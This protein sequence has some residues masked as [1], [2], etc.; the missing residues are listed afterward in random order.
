MRRS[1]IALAAA[2]FAV[3][4]PLGRLAAQK[5]TP[6]QEPQAAFRGTVDTVGIFAT[7]LDKA[8]HLVPDLE[9]TDFE[10]YD[11]DKKQDITLFKKDIQPITVVMMLDTSGSMT[12]NLEFL[13]DAAEAF[14][15]RLVPPLGDRARIGNFDDKLFLSPFFTNNRDDL[16]R[17]IHED[18][19]YGNGTRLWDAIDLSMTGLSH[20]EG[21]RVVLVFTDGDDTT[22][23]KSDGDVLQRALTE[24]FMVYAI[25]LRSHILNTIT[26]PDRGL[27]KLAQETGGGYFELQR[28]ADLNATFTRVADELHRQY[29]IGFTP[30]VRDGKV[31]KLDVRVIKPDMTARAKKTYIAA[32]R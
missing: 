26:T 4:V 30:K 7:V 16:I 10:V 28:A 14:V 21:R 25:G 5:P 3:L 13:K 19:Q 2:L 8:G 15:L 12:L 9:Q 1:F 29:V 32:S 6:T 31:H 17:I 18:L 11:N 20:E 22:S 23:K 24:E 27:R